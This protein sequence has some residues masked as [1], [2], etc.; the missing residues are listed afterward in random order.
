MAPPKAAPRPRN[1]NTHAASNGQG[2]PSGLGGFALSPVQTISLLAGVLVLAG[3]IVLVTGDRPQKIASAI[4]STFETQTSAM[5]FKVK[6]VHV[7]GTSGMAQADVVAATGL[8]QDQP[9]LTLDLKALQAKVEAVGWVKSA[10]VVRL[11]PDTLVIAVVERQRLAVWQN[12]G[13]TKVVDVEGKVIQEANPANFS[14]LP[15]VVGVGAN[16]AAPVIMPMVLSRPRLVSRLEALVRVDQRRWD[17]RL[18]DGGIIQLPAVG[19]D[20]ALI[21]LDQIDQKSRILDLGFERIDLRDPEALAV[22][23]RAGSAPDGL[24]AGGA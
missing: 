24:I 17:L 21:Q 9:I 8:Y 4:T 1:P 12:Q 15:L 3:V 23:P 20:S 10:K 18:K 19:E 11:L 16:E 7:Q 2:G 5:G 14:N 13:Q 6:A 22:R